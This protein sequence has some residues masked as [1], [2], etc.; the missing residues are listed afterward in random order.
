MAQI[1]LTCAAMSAACALEPE[2]VVD[3]PSQP[4]E[5]EASL[6]LDALRGTWRVEASVSS[7]CPAEWQRTMPTGMTQWDHVEEHLVIT[8]PSGQ[9]PSA[10][11]WPRD[12][13]SFTRDIEVSLFDCRASESLTLVIHEHEDNFAAGS[14]TAELTHDGSPSCESLSEEAGLPQRCVT[15]MDWQ[16]IRLGG[17]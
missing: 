2:V 4:D 8:D 15:L 7:D 6:S 14:Y 9:V 5:A 12:A 13:H 10:E 16:A 11:L 3:I 1:A 17:P